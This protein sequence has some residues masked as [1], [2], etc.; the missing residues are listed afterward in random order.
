MK[1][2][3]RARY[4]L[5]NVANGS[6]ATVSPDGRPWNTPLFVAFAADFKFYWSSL[7]DTEHSRNI[8][9]RPDVFLVVFDPTQPDESGSGVYIRATA[10]ELGD[11]ASIRVALALLAKRKN[12][13]PQPAADFTGPQPRRVYEAVPEGIWTNVLNEEGGYYFDER[14]DIDLL[15]RSRTDDH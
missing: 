10:R 6:L 12:R 5:E 8:A 1:L 13:S 11:E 7:S 15:R 3:D 4:V 2:V 14:I 9:V